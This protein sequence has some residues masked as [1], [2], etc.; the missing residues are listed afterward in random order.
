[1]WLSDRRAILLGA[2]ALAGCGFRPVYGEGGTGRALRHAVRAADPVSRADYQFVAAFEDL[3]GRPDSAR[4]ALTYA[5][6]TREMG[7][8]RVSGFGDTRIQ[9]FGA[10]DYTLSPLAG[11][12][13]LATGRIEG[14]TAYSTTGTQLASL[15][16]AE[17]AHLRLMRLLAEGLVGRLLADPTLAAG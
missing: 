16:A 3:L 9:V 4:H 11:G 12:D 14:S 10:L 5:I 13:A 7:G 6:T 17:D 8:G 1:M 15:T 2:L